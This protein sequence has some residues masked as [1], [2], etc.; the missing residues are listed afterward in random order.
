MRPTEDTTVLVTRATDGLG[1]SVATE[2]AARGA[3]VLVLC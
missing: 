1:R 2:L 3:T